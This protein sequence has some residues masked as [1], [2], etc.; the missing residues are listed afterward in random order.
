MATKASKG[1]KSSRVSSS[2][3]IDVPAERVWE[4][5]GQFKALADWHPAVEKSELEQ[6]G[7][8][9]RLSLVGG[10]TIVERL[11]R[12]DDESFKYSYSIVNSPLPVTNY[13]SELKVVKD[14]SGKGCR[15][16]WSSEFEPAGTSAS[17]AEKVIRDFYEAGVKNLQA[18]FRR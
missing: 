8:M 11:E 14:D 18:L 7:K 3:H 12:I 9:R 4:L 6:G 16:E 17:D 1:S 15:V 10:G 2:T 5:I 13:V